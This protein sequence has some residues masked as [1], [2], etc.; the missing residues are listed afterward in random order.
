[1]SIFKTSGFNW[2]KGHICS[3]HW[4]SGFR[5]DINDLPDVPVPP[6]QVTKIKQKYINAIKRFNSAKLTPKK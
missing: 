2:S 3:A 4:S 6:D 1:M 5:K